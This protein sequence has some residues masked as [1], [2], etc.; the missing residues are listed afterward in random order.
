MIFRLII[1]K[2]LFF[3]FT[4][5]NLKVEHVIRTKIGTKTKT[6]TYLKTAKGFFKT[7]EINYFDDGRKHSLYSYKNGTKHGKYVKWNFILKKNK[8]AE[9]QRKYFISEKGNYKN[10]KRNGGL[11]AY[12]PSG[13]ICWEAI[14]HN[15][16]IKGPV[17]EFY[18]N[19]RVYR[20]LNYSRGEK[21]GKYRVYY[22]DG[23]LEIEGE[24]FYGMR[25]CIWKFHNPKVDISEEIEYRDGLPWQG[26]YTNW[27]SEPILSPCENKLMLLGLKYQEGKENI[28]YRNNDNSIITCDEN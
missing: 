9:S 8:Y 15:G 18:S 28:I 12:Y 7:Q 16:I 22:E 10:G 2:I 14:Y 27:K 25:Y 26:T 4:L 13:A 11:R 3:E 24:Y 23:K 20:S 1:V 21:N 6:V 5:G 17:Q 19:G